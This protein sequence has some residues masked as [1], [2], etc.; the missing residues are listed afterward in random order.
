MRTCIAM[1]TCLFVFAACGGVDTDAIKSEIATLKKKLAALNAEKVQV[2]EKNTTI[3]T[4]SFKATGA[5]R[6]AKKSG[7]EDAIATAKQNLD[8]AAAAAQ[9]ALDAEKALDDRIR[10]IKD[11]IRDLEKKLR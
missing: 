8:A 9:Q 4:D 5:Y 6:R 11:K 2:M 3:K 1:L 7:D 10:D